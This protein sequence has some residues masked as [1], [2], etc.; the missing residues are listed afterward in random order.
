MRI[1]G[2]LFLDN[3]LQKDTVISLSGAESRTEKVFTALHEMCMQFDLSIPLWLDK[4]IDEFR[5]HA[6]TRFTADNFMDSFE[7]DYL[8]F[9]VIEE[10]P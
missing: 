5:R 2:K 9:H 3:R 6:K 1:W 8:E 4:N 10:E 7:Y